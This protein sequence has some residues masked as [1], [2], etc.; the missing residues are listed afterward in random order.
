MHIVSRMSRTTGDVELSD[1]KIAEESGREHDTINPFHDIASPVRFRESVSMKNVDEW[2]D[3][4]DKAMDFDD[5]ELNVKRFVIMTILHL[6]PTPI[7]ILLGNI[8][9]GNS[10]HKR[11][12][13]FSPI[14]LLLT[15][16]IVSY[17]L[18]K[19]LCI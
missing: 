8:I 3:I 7:H 15:I 18:R 14:E 1:V 11:H 9:Y 19:I 17:I 2:E 5:G 10:Y 4:Y 16:P 13:S 6:M 12:L